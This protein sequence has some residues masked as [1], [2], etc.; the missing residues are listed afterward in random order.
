MLIGLTHQ[1]FAVIGVGNADQRVGALQE[2]VQ[3]SH[4]HV[5]GRD[6]YGVK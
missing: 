1:V 3:L 6:T 5:L 2:F 4:L